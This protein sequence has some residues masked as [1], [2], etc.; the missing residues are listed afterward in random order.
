M[1]RG[2]TLSRVEFIEAEELPLQNL[3]GCYSI[4]LLY[5]QP[6]TQRQS[7]FLC[8][9][10]CRVIEFENILLSVCVCV[11]VMKCVCVCV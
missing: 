7:L 4:Q 2:G 8:L 3:S 1:S 5:P 6:Q 10:I 11:C 9:F